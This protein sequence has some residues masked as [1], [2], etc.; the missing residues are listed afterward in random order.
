MGTINTRG[1]ESRRGSL[2]AMAASYCLGVF[3]DNYFKQAAMLLAV[4][5]GSVRLQGWAAILFALPFI[6]F[7]AQGGWCADRFPKK[8]VV[9]FSKGLECVAMLIGGVG[10]LMG[11]WP[12]ILAM[13][14]LMGLQSSFFNPALNSSIPELYPAESVPRINAL[15]KLTT[16]LAILSG[17]ALAGVSLDQN[18]FVTGDTPF[19]VILVAVVAVLVALTGM[20]S[21]LGMSGRPAAGGESGSPFPLFGPSQSLRDLKKI[22]R[23]RQLLLAMVSNTYFYFVASIVVLIVN[24]IGLQELQFSQTMTGML[25]V[26]LMLGVCLG[27]A[28]AAQF[29]KHDT[30]TRFLVPSALVMACGLLLAGM[31]DGVAESSRFSWL[32]LSLCIAGIGGGIFLIPVTSFLQV[33]PDAT[34]KGRVLAAAGFCSF[35]AILTSGLVYN[36]FESFLQPTTLISVIGGLGVLSSLAFLFMVKAVSS[37]GWSFT[38]MVLR[39]LL[40]CRYRV[41]VEGLDSIKAQ[42]KEGILFLPNHPALIDPV[43]VMSVLY[44]RFSPR[45]LSSIE[46]IKKPVIWQVMKKFKPITLA[47][48]NRVGMGGKEIVYRTMNAVVKSLKCGENIL[49]YPAGRL[50]RKG[51]ED[52]G[53]NSGVQYILGK[54][55]EVRVVLVR[56]NGLWGSSLSRGMGEAPSPF[57]HLMKYIRALFCNGFFFGPKRRVTLECV[58]DMTL[59]GMDSRTEINRYLEEYYNRIEEKNRRIPYYW[60]QG[61]KEVV[62]SESEEARVSANSDDISQTIKNQVMGKIRE[63]VDAKVLP[64]DSLAADLG[65]DSI[66][67]MELATWIEGEFGV[68]IYDNSSLESVNDCF[69]A[70]GGHLQGNGSPTANTPS[71]KWFLE[72]STPLQLPEGDKITD[73]FLAQVRKNPGKVIL[74]DG[75]V[76]TRN[77]RQLVTGIFALLPFFEEIEGDRVGILLPASVSSAIVYLAALFSGKTPVMFNWTVG[78]ANMAHG[79]GETGVEVIV[80]ATPLVQKIEK[81]QCGRISDL[82]VRCLY[83]DRVLA[84]LN[85]P[86]KI[87]AVTKG[88]FLARSLARKRVPDTAAIL[89]TSGSEARPKAVPLSHGNILANLK[90]FDGLLQLDKETTLLGMLPPFHSLGLVG[91]LILPLCLGMKTVYHANPTEAGVMARII[92]DYGVSMLVA[93]P[94]FLNGILMGAEEK[95]LKSIRLAFTGAEKCP[96]HVLEKLQKMVPEA[97]LCEG[98]GITECSP[99]VS[100]NIPGQARPGTIGRIMPSIQWAI[101]DQTGNRR[102]TEG[103]QGLLLVRGPS[104]FNG[105]LNSPAQ[106][107][108]CEF[109][110]KLWYETGDFVRMDGDGHLVF[111]GR[112]KRFVKVAGEMISLPA[113]ENILLEAMTNVN[114][115]GP[116]LA[117]EATPQDGHPEIVLFSTERLVREQ[118]NELLKK[119]G[120]SALHNIR[121]L[122]EVE[123]IPVLGTGK[124]DY[125]ELQKLLTV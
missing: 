91:T 86:A 14:F 76:G 115:D 25:S 40:R 5:A 67:I 112:K 113:I 114:E 66:T 52:L 32:A 121:R 69:L 41:E 20:I 4:A 64:T 60:W 56:T 39:F 63:T 98:Y 36:S 97:E 45:P 50:Y 101:V 103:E 27:S 1:T 11:S 61:S 42:G 73:L 12:C 109:E 3:N 55:P 51:R 70:A 24:A 96:A 38:G 90:D 44:D 79:I 75:V 65:M 94:T 30:W 72:S 71:S 116:T 21:S 23:D 80:S 17:V 110:G 28:V 82:G 59:H 81:Q 10:L 77:Y 16:T 47:D 6:L 87:A 34:S 92:E 84:E 48:T 93:T 99:L 54:V 35:C 125:K 85:M 37:E 102:V 119:A 95:Q 88:T 31:A 108:F 49:F 74:A 83:L 9:L 120:L 100:I 8:R 19:G 89:F 53:G 29:V 124:T 22:C 104:I 2:G 118:V 111:C 117:V 106:R 46:Q 68:S 15:M 7:S 58:E 13:V 18:W 78:S 57:R 122:V 26:S 43:I 123:S 62:V 107:G 105:Y 33:H